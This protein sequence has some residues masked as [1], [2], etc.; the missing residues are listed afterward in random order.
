MI[1]TIDRISKAYEFLNS[2]HVKRFT[3]AQFMQ[4]VP[5]FL[6][7][8]EANDF[9]THLVKTGVLRSEIVWKCPE[10]YTDLLPLTLEAGYC[11]DCEKTMTLDQ[12]YA[13]VIY[14]NEYGKPFF[15][16]NSFY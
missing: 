9:L 13:L 16:V 11:V 10:C 7:K 8:D 12:R 5:E 2:P 4:K 14:I 6:I 15:E 1:D 3:I